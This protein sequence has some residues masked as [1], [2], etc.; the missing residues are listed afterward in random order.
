MPLF[1]IFRNSAHYWLLSGLF[2]GAATFSPYFSAQAVKGTIQDDPRFLGACTAVW[3]L[4]EL[5]NFSCHL[6]LR[7]LRPAGTRKR[8]I[9][10]G[11]LFELVSCPNY[12]YEVSLIPAIIREDDR[13]IFFFLDWPD[14]RVDRLHRPH[15]VARVGHLYRRRFGVH[16]PMGYGQAPG[17]FLLS[18]CFAKPLQLTYEEYSELPQRVQGLPSP[19]QGHRPLHLLSVGLCSS[20][21][22]CLKGEWG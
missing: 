1:N 12:F 9:P 13:L 14:C 8:G 5:A 15:P 10:R 18:A 17:A 16:V 22:C 3:A 21:T 20:W 11:G 2:L 6:T 19:A 4:A 7:N